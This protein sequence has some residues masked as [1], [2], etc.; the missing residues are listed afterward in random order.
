MR[1][2]IVKGGIPTKMCAEGRMELNHLQLFINIPC[3]IE[4]VLVSASPNADTVSRLPREYAGYADLQCVHLFWLPLEKDAPQR[5]NGGA[6]P[7]M[8]FTTARVYGQYP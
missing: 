3:S 4:Y 7:S 1:T 5:H 6:E 2:L 8:T